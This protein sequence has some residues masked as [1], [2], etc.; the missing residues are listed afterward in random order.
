MKLDDGVCYRALTTRDARF[1]GRFFV[2]VRTTG[3]YCRPICPARTPKREN[4]TFFSCAAA[5]EAAGFRPCL[6]CRPE[7]SPGTPA[8]NGTSAVVSRALRLIG[9][10]AADEG[11]SETLPARVG[12]GERQ[13][14]R[15]FQRHLGASPAEIAWARR[16]HF[17]KTLID[18]TA[19]GMTEVAI[20]AGYRSIRELNHSIRKTF[21]RS[22]REL[23][24][25]RA[26]GHGIA[27]A[28]ARGALTLRLSYRPPLEWRALLEFFRE[29]ATPGVEA[30]D[31]HSYRRTIVW[32]GEPGWFEVSPAERGAQLVLRAELP[33]VRGLIRLAERVRRMFDLNADPLHVAAGLS[34]EP[35][36]RKLV[37]ARPGL[38]VPGAWEGFE[39]AVRAILGQQ[40][41][42][43]AAT[44]LAGRLVQRFGRSVES[45]GPS[46]THLFPDPQTLAHADLTGLG[47][48][49][50]RAE[51][52]RGLARAVVTGTLTLDASRGLEDG[53]A[54]LA[55][56]PGIGEWTAQYI[57]LR[58][59]GEPDG[60]PVGDLGVRR[61]LAT[62]NGMPST[63]AV[64]R[65]AEA[66]RPWRAY[67]VIHLWT[68]EP[69]K[70]K[71]S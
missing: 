9:D 15:L 51:T 47:L 56:L 67:A 38:R 63:Q 65:I 2:G 53:V 3:I 19:L 41:T 32:G 31:D 60:F 8:W 57:A 4:V 34:R 1:D 12:L 6:R 30:V 29:R 16:V 58:A 68:S 17:A 59:F 28:N 55:A 20:S 64:A 7:T 49:R 26:D 61:A 5:A 21:G 52:I 27:A 35:Y 23:R 14:R 11:G 71:R 66:W 37:R 22:P 48:T 25:Q 46:L 69:A 13:L 10:G 44:T 43:R 36:L 39:L 62:G 50:S 40:I 33:T 24:R 45:S 70:E 18:E 42:V 54:R